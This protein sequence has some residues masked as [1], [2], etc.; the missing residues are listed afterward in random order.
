[1]VDMVVPTLSQSRDLRPGAA[2]AS[3][4]G[5]IHICTVNLMSINY[6]PSQEASKFKS[7]IDTQFQNYLDNTEQKN[8]KVVD[9]IVVDN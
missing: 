5:D 8:F 6:L 7:I 4:I 1:M 2:S 3:G 9:E